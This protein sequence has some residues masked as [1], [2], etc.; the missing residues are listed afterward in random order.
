[1]TDRNVPEGWKLS[2]LGSLTRREVERVGFSSENP[3]RVLSSTKHHGLVPSDTYFKG[4]RI[5]SEDLAPYRVVRP[6]WFAYA[7]NHL[8]EGSIG[9]NEGDLGC[10]S[11]MYT[12][13]SAT[14][15]ADP[16]YLWHVL[17]SPAV[18]RAYALHEQASVDRRGAIRYGD[19]AKIEVL[20]PPLVEQRAIATILDLVDD[21]LDQ[22]TRVVS[23]LESA[24]RG[25]LQEQFSRLAASGTV[26][27]T[28]VADFQVGVPF[29]SAEYQSAGV[30][31]LRPGNLQ[32][33]EFAVWDERHTVCLP[34]RWLSQSGQYVVHPGE[35]VMNLTAQ[36]LLEGFL[37]RVAIT[38]PSVLCLLNQR[39]ARLRVHG[40]SVD[41]FFWAMRSPYVRAQIHRLGQ[42]MKVQHLYNGDVSSLN[43]PV[44]PSTLEQERIAAELWSFVDRARSERACMRRLAMVR[45]GLLD[46]LLTGRGRTVPG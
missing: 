38:P 27:L 43:I 6:N 31:L 44:P 26:K 29:P 35:V 41:Y 23:Q 13:F 36:S 19:F 2:P 1:M 15:C 25:L 24:K 9:L 39:I 14:D 20:Q 4:R 30:P 42:G 11:P 17:K 21:L 3:P 37:G 22:T 7:T 16:R 40:C 10:V 28:D 45:A 33:D 34:E 8:A 32:A 18:M 46:D 12:V 5:Y